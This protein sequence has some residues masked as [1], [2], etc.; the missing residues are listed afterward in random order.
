MRIVYIKLFNILL[1]HVQRVLHMEV[2]I[3]IDRAKQSTKVETDNGKQIQTV[4][5]EPII[6]P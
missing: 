4:R 5:L 3:F 2:Q 1:P 6:S